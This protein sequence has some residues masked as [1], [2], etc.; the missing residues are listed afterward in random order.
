MRR[1]NDL[2]AGTSAARYRSRTNPATLGPSRRAAGSAQL[3][4]PTAHE[5]ACRIDRVHMQQTRS[6][7]S[8]RLGLD[9]QLGTADRGDPAVA[10]SI[11]RRE[12]TEALKRSWD[13]SAAMA[14]SP[15][16]V[17]DPS[18]FASPSSSVGLGQCCTH[19]VLFDL[20][21]T[22]PGVEHWLL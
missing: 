8:R 16:V 11:T 14:Q 19:G 22:T 17:I 7:R 18:A 21:K 10:N 3:A 9:R 13:T 1:G 6:G 15:L 2:E 5:E 20:A 12:E 4:E